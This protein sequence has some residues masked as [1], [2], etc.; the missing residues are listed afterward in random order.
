MLTLNNSCLQYNH[1]DRKKGH[2]ER[3]KQK[4]I[5]TSVKL[6]I[7]PCTA[8]ND[9]VA[10]W[11]RQD[12]FS[13]SAALKNSRYLILSGNAKLWGCYPN[14]SSEFSAPGEQSKYEK[15]SVRNYFLL[16]VVGSALVFSKV[17]SWGQCKPHSVNVTQN[18]SWAVRRISNEEESHSLLWLGR[19]AVM[20]NHKH[21]SE[22]PSH[23]FILPHWHRRTIILTSIHRSA[24][25]CH[26]THIK[27]KQQQIE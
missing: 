3:G 24:D 19:C 11:C 2:L 1:L 26:L 15:Q 7:S 14:C 20:G 22:W 18:H 12:T 10:L 21:I 5:F 23:T 27:T 25:N 17:G 16:A 9:K 4:T 8:N 13:F 6:H